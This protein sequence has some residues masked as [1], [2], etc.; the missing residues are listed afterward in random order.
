[1]TSPS[2]RSVFLLGLLL[3][4]GWVLAQD[5]T[6]P[7][8][9]GTY[10]VRIG[11][12]LAITVQK[13]PEYSLSSVTVPLD[14]V[15]YYPLAG[16]LKV[17]DKTLDELT[18]LIT[19]ALKR[20]LRQPAVTVN[21]VRSQ[22][23]YVYVWGAVNKPG[24]VD[25]DAAK[26]D[27]LSV[28]GAVGMAG[29]YSYG[30]D[31]SFVTVVRIGQEP[32]RVP[33]ET[34]RPELDVPSDPGIKLVAGDTL[35]VP[36]IKAWVSV[37]GEVEQPGHFTL[38][39]MDNILSL[40]AQAKGLT[41]RA[42]RERALLLRP[43]GEQ[44]EL[45]IGGA[46]DGTIDASK[47]PQPRDG[48]VVVFLPARNDVVVLGEVNKPGTIELLPEMTVLDALA[49]AG[50]QTKQADLSKVEI[51]QRDGTTRT[52]VLADVGG[53][54]TL[55]FENPEDGR[56]Y[57]GE[58]IRVPKTQRFVSVLGFVQSPGVIDFEPGDRVSDV[59]ARAGGDIKGQAKPQ[60]TTLLRAGANRDQVEVVECDLTRILQGQAP[61][62]NIEV[63]NGDMIYVPGEA[64]RFT[65][66]DL[67]R[68]FLQLGS[69]LVVAGD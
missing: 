6:T 47:L 24:P 26:V 29:G 19:D 64:D 16:A 7:L 54:L 55:K 34:K 8:F 68:T 31:D 67:I 15:I 41:P 39:P 33:L 57:G 61:E 69:I 13:H 1:M 56:L 32:Q 65:R 62:A 38:R 40:L 2:A 36:E 35:I 23:R 17:T 42:D 9:P 66:S 48:D 59:V 28:P 63:R 58:T 10:R 30:A 25:L 52:V 43:N 37:V 14:G 21:V 20:E 3:T 60:H 50:G 22:P 49:A 4:T 51:V 12:T 53:Q 27:S 44:I 45:S 5:S 11:D 46:I 18:Q